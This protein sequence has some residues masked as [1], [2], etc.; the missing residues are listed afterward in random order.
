MP[1]E[2]DKIKKK[3]IKVLLLKKKKKE[4]E[5]TGDKKKENVR[6]NIIREQLIYREA[7]K[8]LMSV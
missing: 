7:G 8:D 3:T 5:P 6:G 2:N 4:K 1:K